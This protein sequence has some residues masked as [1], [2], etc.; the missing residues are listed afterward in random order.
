MAQTYDQFFHDLAVRESVGVFDP[1]QQPNYQAL[2]SNGLNYLGAYQFNEWTMINLG[3]YTDDGTANVNTWQ[4]AHFTGKDGIYSEQDYLNN[5]GVQNQA[6]R[7]WMQDWVWGFV[8]A[9]GLD[10]HIGQTIGGI[11]ITASGL[12]AGAHLRGADAV[13]QFIDSGGA[14]DP[15]DPYGT[16]VSQYLSHFGGYQT[17]FDP[18]GS[19]PASNPA[20]VTAAP[21]PASAPVS[22]D[23]SIVLNVSA[24]NWNGSPQFLVSVDGVQKGGTQVTAASHADGASDAITLSNIVGAGPHDVAVTFLNDAWGGTQSTD[25]NLYVNSADYQGQ[26]FG[27]ASATL[28]WN[29][30]AHVTVG[31]PNSATG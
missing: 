6:A 12:L 10:Q 20:P 15:Q 13:Q 31:A 4:T 1:N 22:S 24:D 2:G 9:D 7:A 28:L 26:H 16:P 8:K 3:Y 25:R 21:A 29:S 27:R 5:P 14:V 17:P 30:T 18:G 11:P 19:Q 23:N